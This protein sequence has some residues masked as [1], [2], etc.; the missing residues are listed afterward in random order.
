VLEV[1]YS[2]I[3]DR[4]YASNTSPASKST[5]RITLLIFFNNQ[6]RY[7]L[8]KTGRYGSRTGG[9]KANN[10]KLRVDFSSVN[11]FDPVLFEAGVELVKVNGSKFKLSNACEVRFIVEVDLSPRAAACEVDILNPLRNIIATNSPA[12]SFMSYFFGLITFLHGNR[13]H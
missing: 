12:N 3:S 7:G 11:D 4:Y 1:K 5:H 6:G 8:R 9:R 10:V 2:T 13:K